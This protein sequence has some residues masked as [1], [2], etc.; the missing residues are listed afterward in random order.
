ML[1]AIEVEPIEVVR[2]GKTRFTL[3]LETDAPNP[4]RSLRIGLKYLLRACGLRAIEIREHPTK[5]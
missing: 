4:Y 5:A 2:D 3:V 1:Q